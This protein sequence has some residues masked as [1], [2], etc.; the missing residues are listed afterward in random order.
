MK[1][2]LILATLGRT[3]DVGILIRSLVA[4]SDRR[5]ELLVV[6]QNTDDR[7][8]RFIHEGQASGLD[9]THLRLDRPSLSGARNLGLAHATGDVVAFPDDDC[10]YEKDTVKA[11][12]Q[13][14]SEDS[15][16][17][18]IIGQWVEQALAQNHRPSPEPLSSQAWRRFRGGNASSITLFIKRALLVRLGGFDERFGVGRWYGAGEETDF[19]LR[20]LSSGATL[21]SRPDIRVPHRFS[22]TSATR[23]LEDCGNT[24][25]RAAE[26]AA[27]M[28]NIASPPGWSFAA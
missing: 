2:S 18:G 12:L 5:F 6:D 20:A 16:C 21:I 24:R 17:D 4:Q 27:S 3:D 7:L 23:L 1:A 22:T 25:K 13:A 10:W 19:I 14:F 26:L 11:M 8:L 28:P 9:I 15:T